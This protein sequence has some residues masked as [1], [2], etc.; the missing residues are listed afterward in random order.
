MRRVTHICRTDIGAYR[1]FGVGG[2]PAIES[3][4]Q[5]F[6]VVERRLSIKRRRLFAEPVTSAQGASIDWWTDAE[7]SVTPF[8]DLSSKR[9]EAVKAEL[10]EAFAEITASADALIAARKGDSVVVG[11]LLKAAMISPAPEG[12]YLIGDQP[13]LTS[14]A[15]E[16]NQN[17]LT[18]FTVPGG[19][20]AAAIIDV[21]P[22]EPRAAEPE[23][24]PPP[25]PERER[26]GWAFAFPWWLRWLLLALLLLLLLFFLLRA[27]D[28]S[29]PSLP[30]LPSL[31][32]SSS[33]SAKDPPPR[34]EAPAGTDPEAQAPGDGAN[35]ETG[36][37]GD[38][39][40]GSVSG[41]GPDVGAGTGNGAGGGN[42]VIVPSPLDEG[43]TGS[44]GAGPV[45]GSGGN[46][47]AVLPPPELQTDASDL[48]PEARAAIQSLE[49]ARAREHELRR[50]VGI[51]EARIAAKQR[52]CV[53]DI[54]GDGSSAGVA[55][56]STG[57]ATAPDA[58]VSPETEVPVETPS[59][60]SDEAA[61]DPRPVPET[62]PE[63]DL[64]ADQRAAEPAEPPTATQTPTPPPEQPQEAQACEPERQPWDAPEVVVV[65]DGSGSMGLAADTPP[66]V[67]H[68]L[69]KRAQAGDVQAVREL[70]KYEGAPGARLIDRAQDAV[71]G[72]IDSLP[73]DVDVG[74]IDFGACDSVVNHAFYDASQRETLKALIKRTEPRSGTPLTRALERAGRIIKG[75]TPDEE[76]VI[77]VLTDG[78]DTCGGDVCAAAQR[79]AREKPGVVVNVLNLGAG[80]VGRCIA[81]ATGGRVFDVSSISSLP[82]ALVAASEEPPVPAACR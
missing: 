60:P 56:R 12:L 23:S 52:A 17:Q 61:V 82:E 57:P 78:Y 31:D 32:G 58:P 68:S 33:D 37:G 76:G 36:Q 20:A 63:S 47:T 81:D 80:D 38:L 7:G 65:M 18:P 22:E 11:E 50:R 34:E 77:I 75:R 48:S 67:L 39:S 6:D 26:R 21:T 29:L 19:Q 5:I 10:Q 43:G 24:E 4:D 46:G 9:Q 44:D 64:Q 1:P 66:E 42:V 49:D 2:A 27:C 62:D 79:I 59:A 72:M 8:K 41:G 40:D 71:G 54:C 55:P 16:P 28:P 73:S 30:G 70:E 14:W 25:E 69:L 53:P 45:P 15:H 74:F 13:V 51:L 3:A 35:M